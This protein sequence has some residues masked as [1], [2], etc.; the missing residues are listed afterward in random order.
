MFSLSTTVSALALTSFFCDIS[1]CGFLEHH[2]CNAP[3]HIQNTQKWVELFY[4][5]TMFWDQDTNEFLHCCCDIHIHCAFGS[6]H[7]QCSGL[8]G[9]RL[10]IYEWPV[11]FKDV[12]LCSI[13]DTDQN[14]C[15]FSLSFP[16]FLRSGVISVNA[17]VISTL[18]GIQNWWIYHRPRGQIIL[19]AISVAVTTK[20]LTP[21]DD[22]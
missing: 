13:H 19:A 7:K 21:S 4:L 22:F 1:I 8:L 2:L 15:H 17:L 18:F 6:H 5:G 9:F 14:R 16:I 20:R 3:F 11:P 12:D 10:L